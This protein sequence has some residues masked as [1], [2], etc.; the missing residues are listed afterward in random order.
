MKKKY[1]KKALLSFLAI[2][3]Y[4]SSVSSVFAQNYDPMKFETIDAAPIIGNGKIKLDPNMTKLVQEKEKLASEYYKAK[5]VGD[6]LKINTIL[7]TANEGRKIRQ[8]NTR[9]NTKNNE[10]QPNVYIDPI[11]RRCLYFRQHP[12]ERS[13][14]CGYA[15]IQTLL[16]Y[17]RIYRSQT[18]I[19]DAVYRRDSACPWYLSNGN[20]RDQFPVP[21]YLTRMLDYA[22][23]PFPYGEVETRELTPYEIKERVVYTT[24]RRYGV[25]ACG[26]SKGKRKNHPSILP[27]YPSWN[28]SHWLAIE[29]YLDWGNRIYIVDSAKSDAVSWGWRIRRY[30]DVSTY[31][32]AAFASHR[33]L[34]W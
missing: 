32:L 30:Y 16:D 8:H 11:E 12:Q 18:E 7:N 22:Y 25:M 23:I 26:E 19:A 24:D 5:M 31:T 9:N 14:Y 2:L 10:Y 20:S 13:Y 29:G 17:D 33:G 6:T 3:L 1:Y 34:I 28:V 27:D 4:F 15:A 21:V